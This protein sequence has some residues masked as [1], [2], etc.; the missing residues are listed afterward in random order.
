[1]IFLLVKVVRKTARNHIPDS[2]A[3][4]L[5]RRAP[6]VNQRAVDSSEL[7]SDDDPQTVDAAW[8]GNDDNSD[9]ESVDSELDNPLK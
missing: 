9:A 5:T 2:F 6:S 4:T 1:M 8:N 3:D 7:D